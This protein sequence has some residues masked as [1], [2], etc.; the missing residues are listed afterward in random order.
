MNEYI[1]QRKF[2]YA[3]MP[4]GKEKQKVYAG[5]QMKSPGVPALGLFYS[6]FWNGRA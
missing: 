5:R 1:L 3:I 2:A 4:V 6:L